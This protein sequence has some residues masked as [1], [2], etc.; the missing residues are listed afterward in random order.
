MEMEKNKK[1]I[2]VFTIKD[3]NHLIVIIKSQNTINVIQI[4]GERTWGKEGYGK[5]EGVQR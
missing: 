1:E 5:E 2:K 4:I 3:N